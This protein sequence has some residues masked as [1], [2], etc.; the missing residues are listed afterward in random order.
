MKFTGKSAA[1]QFLSRN[2][3]YYIKRERMWIA[4][5]RPLASIAQANVPN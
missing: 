3:N 4:I 2:T 5:V 1:V